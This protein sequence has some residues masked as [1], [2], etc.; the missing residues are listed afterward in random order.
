MPDLVVGPL[1]A[2]AGLD[3]GALCLLAG[4]FTVLETSVG[5]GLLIPGDSVVLLAATTVTTPNRFAALVAVTVLGSVTGETVGYLLG[6][7]WGTR[8]R[9]SRLGRRLGEDRWVRAEAFLTGRGGRAVAAARFVAVVH[10]LVPVVAGTVGMPYRRFV[11]WA[12]LG[13]VAWSVL[14]VGI[15]MTAG[16]SWRE[17]GDRLGLVGL[18]VLGGV[19]VVVLVVRAGRRGSVPTARPP[20]GPGRPGSDVGPPAPAR[21]QPR[22]G[23]PSELAATARSSSPEPV[24]PDPA[25]PRAT[26]LLP[27]AHQRPCL[28]DARCAAAGQVWEPGWRSL[29]VLDRTDQRAVG[30]AGRLPENPSGEQAEAGPLVS[31][32]SR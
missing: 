25:G 15:G 3:P 5:I 14:Y 10:A 26:R 20:E 28:A 11:G 1:E 4:L 21:S 9:T 30:A 23:H 27:A 16:A 24:G 22:R 17:Y 6:R 19:L 18:A 12:A 7:R 32:W 2:L 31:H 29:A 8:V 13:A